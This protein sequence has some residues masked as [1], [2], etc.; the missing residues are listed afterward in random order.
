MGFC[1]FMATRTAL[2]TSC[3]VCF[4]PRS[5]VIIPCFKHCSTALHSLLLVVISLNE[6]W[7]ISA[8]LR[9]V[10]IGLHIFIPAISGAHPCIGSYKPLHGGTPHNEALGKHPILPHKTLISSLN[11]SP[12][13]LVVSNTPSSLL[14]F[15]IKCIAAASTRHVSILTVGKLD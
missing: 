8:T 6:C 12:N 7:N 14:V 2:A 10:P 4:P 1:I 3:K 15:F 9:I 5:A 11:I 13:K